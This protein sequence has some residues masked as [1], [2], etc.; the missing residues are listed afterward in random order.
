M[1]MTRIPLYEP[2]PE[3]PSLPEPDIVEQT[4][5]K[6]IPK[7]PTVTDEDLDEHAKKVS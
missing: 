3:G 7:R 6:D 2:V 5:Q 1:L 4:M